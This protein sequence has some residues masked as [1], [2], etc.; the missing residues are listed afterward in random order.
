MI[1]SEVSIKK[2]KNN[3]GR[4]L[5][6]TMLMSGEEGVIVEVDA[7]RGLTKRLTELGFTKDSLTKVISSAFEGGGR[8]IVSI[9]DSKIALSCGIAYKII[10]KK[11]R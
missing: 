4:L 5:P 11:L 1:D 2:L 6:L 10:V 9:K 3:I 7:G 8:M